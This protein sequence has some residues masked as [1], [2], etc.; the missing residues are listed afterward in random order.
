MK[1]ARIVYEVEVYRRKRDRKWETRIRLA[2]GERDIIFTSTG[3][4]YN[5]SATAMRIAKRVF[6]GCYGIRFMLESQDGS[7]KESRPW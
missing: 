6:A 7:F 2:A 3:Q 5:R 4:G 1:K